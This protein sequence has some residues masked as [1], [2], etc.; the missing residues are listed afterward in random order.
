MHC[1]YYMVKRSCVYTQMLLK[2]RL[3]TQSPDIRLSKPLVTGVPLGAWGGAES[4]R[5]AGLHQLD[6]HVV[7]QLSFCARYTLCNINSH[8]KGV[9]G[10][11]L[12]PQKG[13][14]Q[15]DSC[16]NSPL[17]TNYQATLLITNHTKPKPI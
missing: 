9:K 11:L 16:R 4:H 14:Q 8:L 17:I 1:R 7:V 6:G 10:M 15:T 2:Q 3:V 5:K 13:T 12:A